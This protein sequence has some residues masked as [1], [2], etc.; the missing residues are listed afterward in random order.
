MLYWRVAGISDHPRFGFIV[1]KT[2]GNAVNRNLARRRFK[3][4]ARCFIEGQ[5]TGSDLGHTSVDVVIRA[6]PGAAKVDWVSLEDELV[7]LLSVISLPARGGRDA[8]TP[9]T[10]KRTAGQ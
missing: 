2:V 1:A 5:G 9:D 8:H 3:S 7:S 4:I 6:L 10:P